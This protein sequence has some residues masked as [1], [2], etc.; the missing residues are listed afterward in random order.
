MTR[1]IIF[2]TILTIFYSC[3]TNKRN[4]YSKKSNNVVISLYETP[5]RSLPTFYNLDT[6]EIMNNELDDSSFA[7][8][9][10]GIKDTVYSELKIDLKKKKTTYIYEGQQYI[11]YFIDW[12]MILINKKKPFYIY[13]ILDFRGV[14]SQE[15]IYWTKDFG[16]I[17]RKSLYWR[18]F[19]TYEYLND[20]V[21]NETIRILCNFIMNDGEFYEVKDWKERTKY[22]V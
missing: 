5:N 18:S 1:K 7:Y 10:K 21:K 4:N 9:S 12:K 13:R 14:D 8:R 11:S 3:E 22:G 2:L 20:E 19:I 15:F 6:L 16:I 17:L